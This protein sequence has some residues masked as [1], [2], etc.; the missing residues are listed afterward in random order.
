MGK[1]TC[2]DQGWKIILL[3]SPIAKQRPRVVKGHSGVVGHAY[4]PQEKLQEDN[5]WIAYGQ[6]R[7]HWQE[8]CGGFDIYT[9]PSTGFSLRFSFFMDIPRSWSKKKK[10]LH[11]GTHHIYRPDLDNILKFYMDILQGA[12]YYDDKQVHTV[13]AEKRYIFENEAPRTEIAVI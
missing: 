9:P 5:Y 3:G 6:I 12:L 8:V 7:E 13:F 11:Y 10:K 1:L 4:N 2:S